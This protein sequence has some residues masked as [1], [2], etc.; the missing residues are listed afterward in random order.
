MKSFQKIKSI[1][2][3]N[4]NQIYTTVKSTFS[5]KNFRLDHYNFRD[6]RWKGGEY[7]SAYNPQFTLT[8]EEK[9]AN[10]KLPV[11]ERILDFEKYIKHKGQLKTTTKIFMQDVEPFPRLKIMMLCQIINDLLNEFDNDFLYKLVTK[12]YIKY[13]MEVVDEYESIAEIESA[14]VDFDSVEFLIEKLHDEVTHLKLLLK[15]DFYK[16]M[17]KE[18]VSNDDEESVGLFSAAA[19][20]SEFGAVFDDEKNT[21]KK[22]E[23]SERNKGQ[24]EF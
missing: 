19:A 16:E 1:L 18:N 22:H 24:F 2:K 20:N 17:L 5:N 21:Y 12:E 11:N 15:D 3:S 23:K 7:P 10:N 8:E 13:I 9:I 4:Q 14:L 6:N